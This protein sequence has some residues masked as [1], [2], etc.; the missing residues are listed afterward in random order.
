MQSYVHG[1]SEKEQ[2]RLLTQANTL[3]EILHRNTLFP[4]GSTIL[5]A[6][7]GV[8]AQTIQLC[9][10]NPDAHITAVDI[11]GDSVIEARKRCAHLSNV[12]FKQADILKE[13]F[14][15][16]S[17]DHLF[18]CFV[19]EHLP[20]HMQ[21]L[22]KLIQVVKPGGTVTIIEGDH[23][24]PLFFPDSEAARA[25]I[26]CQSILQKRKGGNSNLGRELFP[27][28]QELNLS[29]IK[30]TP[31]IVYTDQN[32]PQLRESFTKGTFIAMVSA[33]KEEALA[34]NLITSVVWKEGIAALMRAAHEGTFSY[35]FFKATATVK[36]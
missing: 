19:L 18:L 36:R 1:Y 24:S 26:N 12:D 33:V 35:T 27:L 28:M 14:P 31:H 16:A 9:E 22:Q 15:E 11:S 4:A 3:A 20:N 30:T 13:P 6:G 29:D 32:Y 5:E 2:S 34:E 8:G 23:G 10:R 7:C 17:F 21:S 25:V